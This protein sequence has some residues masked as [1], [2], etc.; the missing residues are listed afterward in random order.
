MRCVLLSTENRKT[1]TKSFRLDSHI[2]NSLS[3]IAK[4]M[5]ISESAYVSSVLERRLKVEPLVQNI[6]GIGLGKILFQEILAQ[7]NPTGLEL[8]AAEIASQNIPFIF[9]LLE[10]QLNVASLGWYIK[11]IL[12]SWGWFKMYAVNGEKKHELKLFHN[13][14]R[15]WSL[16]LR[17][18]LTSAYELT[19]IR[20]EI[21]I[22]DRLVKISLPEDDHVQNSYSLVTL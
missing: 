2:A 11:E 5:E 8:V 16:F 7:T 13:Y 20:P 12:Q 18:Y 4:N 9:E 6:E 19:Q 10:L 1:V 14:G 15:R 22:T 17:A 21:T 3:K